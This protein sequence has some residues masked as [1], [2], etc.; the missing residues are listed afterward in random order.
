MTPKR[1]RGRP[2]LSPDSPTARITVRIPRAL[3][4]RAA[5]SGINSARVRELIVAELGAQD[6]PTEPAESNVDGLVVGVDVAP[7]AP[8][9]LLT[10][11][12][13]PAPSL[14]WPW[15]SGLQGPVCVIHSV[16]MTEGELRRWAISG[17]ASCGPFLILPK[18]PPSPSA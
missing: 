8:R 5:A 6:Q 1:P 11:A 14:S 13:V 3:A 10:H 17:L 18:Q 16:E 15:A 4:D 7:E 2:A 9:L 12:L